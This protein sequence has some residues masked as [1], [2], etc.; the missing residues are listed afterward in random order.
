MKR[1]ATE[2]EDDWFRQNEI[3]LLQQARKQRELHVAKLRAQE[4]SKQLEQVREAHWLKCPKC[5]H[6]MEVTRTEG[7]EIEQ[8]T[9]CGGL[10]FDRGELDTLLMKKKSERFI[11]Y[12]KFF[13]LD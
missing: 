1:D 4:Q 3:G 8:C 12:R 2:R 6:D 7:I 5:G 13:D 11:F 10:Y 9:L